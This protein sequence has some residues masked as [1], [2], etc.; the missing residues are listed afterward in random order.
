MRFGPKTEKNRVEPD[1]Q[2][3]HGSD[4]V[5]QDIQPIVIPKKRAKPA[6]AHASNPHTPIPTPT[7]SM[8]INYVV[9]FFSSAEMK[10]AVSK[11]LPKCSSF[12]LHSE[13]P[14]DTVKAQLLVKISDALGDAAYLDFSKYNLVVSILC[15]IS[16]PG[17]PLTSDNNYD[18]F[19]ARLK[20]RKV[21]EKFFANVTITQL[22]GNNNKENEPAMNNKPKKNSRKD[23]DTLP[24][25]VEKTNNIQM[26]QQHW[27]CNKRQ[28]NCVGVYCY[29]DHEGNHLSL[30]HQRL[31]C[32]ASAMVY[33]FFEFLSIF[34]FSN[35]FS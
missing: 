23:P 34:H 27:K 18:L 7:V 6:S 29:I 24:G 2:T 33:F 31:D 22:N 4:I 26:L 5:V 30:S 16:K 32:W 20:A 1:L 12:Q 35:Q 14:W 11:R 8:T 25:N 3:L 15:V 9:S 19:L 17:I 10:K 21:K 28:N 13:E